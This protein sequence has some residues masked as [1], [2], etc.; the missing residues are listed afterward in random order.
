MS[1]GGNKVVQGLWIGQHLTKMERLA[2]T[3]FVANGHEFHLY[4]YGK[5][6]DVPCGTNLLD[7]NEILP[8]NEIFRFGKSA[9]YAVFADLFR[10]KLLVEKGGWWV[11]MDL[12]CLKPF[13][14]HAEYVFA[15][16]RDVLGRVSLTNGIIKVPKGSEVLKRALA[17]CQNENVQQLPWAATGPD[18]LD[19]LVSG[20]ELAMYCQQPVTFCPVDPTR[21]L[22]LVLPWPTSAV[23]S[24]TYTVHLWNEM[25]RRYPLDKDQV[26]APSSLYEQLKRRYLS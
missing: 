16:E 19:R 11:D 3:S 24:N 13:D 15:T 25:W 6:D 12:V 9:T 7:A 20:S 8:E 22:S 26:Y 4:V 14:F 2:I 21:W 5:I 10:Y 1:S 17:F 23:T 18:L